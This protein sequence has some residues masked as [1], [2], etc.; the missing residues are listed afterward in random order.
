[1]DRKKY[2]D[3]LQKELKNRYIDNVADIVNDYETLLDDKISDGY[4]EN[5]VLDEW[6]NPCMLAS[7]YGENTCEIK[8]KEKSPIAYKKGHKHT[9][10]FI[11]LQL[12]NI[13]LFLILFTLFIG[14]VSVLSATSFT[15]IVGTIS[16]TITSY[17]F[18]VM[19]LTDLMI[20]L[21]GAVALTSTLITSLAIFIG[22]TYTITYNYI[23]FNCNLLR[24]N[25]LLY[26]K[27]IHKKKSLVLI[28]LM[29]LIFTICLSLS[30]NNIINTFKISN[31]ETETVSTLIDKNFDEVL[32]DGNLEVEIIKGSANKVTYYGQSDDF[33]YEIDDNK[34]KISGAKNTLSLGSFSF[35]IIPY[36][37]RSDMH[38]FGI[39]FSS[40]D[41]KLVLEV[42]DDLDYLKIYGTSI[43]V[44]EV[45]SDEYEIDGI[46][47][48]ILLNDADSKYVE[49]D[50]VDTHFFVNDSSIDKIDLNGMRTN[51]SIIASSIGELNINSINANVTLSHSLFDLYSVDAISV[52]TQL[53]ESVI[54]DVDIDAISKRPEEIQETQD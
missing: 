40:Y 17:M 13:A 38:I 50:A 22:Y 46:T 26:K 49:V 11:A 32:I 25:K 36:V 43:Y 5:E 4:H 15:V 33:S 42:E 9:V 20:I 19:Q 27:I 3:E 16:F 53:T 47:A 14:V 44:E 23:L 28:L 48:H 41:S 7:N 24:E 10:L 1:M 18:D 31:D 2:F 54:K 45:K 29:S 52:D 35:G 51:T 8:P 6:G 37:D 21:I 34:L 39:D 12:L 30:S